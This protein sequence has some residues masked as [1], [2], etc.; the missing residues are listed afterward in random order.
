[1]KKNNGITLLALIITVIIIIILAGVTLY[2][3]IRRKRNYNYF[4]KGYK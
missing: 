4:K 1:M 3:T 2:L